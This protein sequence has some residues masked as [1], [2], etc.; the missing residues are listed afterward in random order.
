[1]GYLTQ[2]TLPWLTILLLLPLIGALL[3]LLAGP[4]RLDDR[5]V[6]LGATLWSLLPLGLV[7]FL[8]AGFDATAVAAGQGV[9]QYV[10]RIPWGDA[11][12]VDYFVGIDG[13]SL[14]LVVLTAALTPVALLGSWRVNERVRLHYALLLLLEAAMLGFFLS[15][16]FFFF[17]VFWE[18]SLIPAFFLI[19]G[20]GRTDGRRRAAL[21]FV[22]YTVAASLG[23]LVL[24]PLFYLATS[25][26]G[27]PTFDL[28][29]LGRLGMGLG[30][31]GLSGDLQTII[32]SYLDDSGITAVLGRFPLLYTSIAFWGI[33]IG[34]AVKL[35]VWPF[36]TWLPDTY[37][38][39]PTATSVLLAAVMS[40]MGAYGM[41]RVLLPLLPEAAREAAPFVGALALIGVLVGAFGAL[42][43][44]RGDMKRLIGYTSINHMGYVALAV[45]AVAASGASADSRTIALNG[46][47]FQMVAHGLS[48][49]ALFLL[50]HMIAE[51]SGGYD[52]TSSGGLR[53]TAPLLAGLA[54]VVFFAN[55]GL[56]GLAGFVGEFFIFR[57]VWA[58]WPLY[59]LLATIGL[60]VTALALL[61]LYGQ[62]F[63]GKPRDP[64]AL[65]PLA[66]H[67]LLAVGPLVAALIFF[68]IY[69]APIMDLSNRAALAFAE[70]LTRLAL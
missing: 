58:A 42:A 66:A 55:L 31:A 38:E 19:D 23:L 26:A 43:H 1:M 2:S 68:G 35:A 25:H 18:L 10:E 15:L 53:T 56:P 36:H 46:A 41:L 30:G 8:W 57:G 69:P 21:T 61:R 28:I 34:F 62:V 29:E 5:T 32:F 39:A 70:L 63:H 60:V 7:I 67:E 64:A 59:A 11:Q 40:K 44:V 50:A 17:F 65:Q 24:F 9:G 48:T 45:A 52:A 20:W 13:L 22:V 14:P 54:G 6:K 4:L 33:F 37:A 16:N 49:A 47:L 12:R 3:P 51:R 27:V